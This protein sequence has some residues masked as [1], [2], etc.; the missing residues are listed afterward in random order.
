MALV[1][2]RCP[3]SLLIFLEHP[4]SRLRPGAFPFKSLIRPAPAWGAREPVRA[5]GAPSSGL[6]CRVLPDCRRCD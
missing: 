1:A 4:C 5:I 3:V 6:Q 2:R